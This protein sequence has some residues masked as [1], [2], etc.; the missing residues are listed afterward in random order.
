MAEQP[1]QRL[2]YS[3]PVVPDLPGTSLRACAAGDYDRHWTTLARHLMQWHL[4]DT[5]VRPGW[6]F[7]GD[8]YAWRATSDPGAYVSCF[9]HVVD[10][11]RAVPGQQFAFDWN[12]NVGPGPLDATTA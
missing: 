10:A 7:N 8:W 5:I 11:M 1:N 12:V 6:E 3:L 9:R 4:T 2:E